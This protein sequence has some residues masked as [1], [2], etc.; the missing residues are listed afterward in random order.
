M[1]HASIVGPTDGTVP[2]VK[3][4]NFT[5]RPGSRW[6]S[7]GPKRGVA[8][9]ARTLVGVTLG[10]LAAYGALAGAS[11]TADAA[12]AVAT[13]AAT[14]SAAPSPKVEAAETYGALQRNFYV[15]SE[16][17]YKGTPANSC[18]TYSCLWPFTNATAGTA[19]LAGTP[20]ESLFVSGVNARVAGLA[21]YADDTEV[22]PGG[23]PQPPAYESAVAPPLGPGGATYYDDNAWVGLNLV[24]AYQETSRTKDLTLAQDEFDFAVAGWDASSTDGCPGGIFWEDVAGSQR[25]ATANGANAEL[26]AELALLT[27]DSSDLTWAERIY[28]WAVTCLGTSSGLYDDHVEPNGS[29]DSTVWS[30]NQGVMVG[31]GVLLDK[32]T[33]TGAYLT[34]AEQTASAAVAH[35]GTGSVLVNQGTAFNAIYFRDLYL[36]NQVA[37]DSAYAAEAQSFATTMWSQR[38]PTGLINPQYG[39]NG[40]APMIEIFGLLAGSPPTP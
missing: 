27:N 32:A 11:A 31:A 21:H 10:C 29:V 13:P 16:H 26:G 3:A 22:S 34:Q 4:Q 14:P 17:L 36:L 35:F 18:A 28:Q 37:P 33:G 24:H 38:Q 39:V 8:A 9:R 15:A 20:G 2:G 25:N 12:T 30:Y 5:V 40:T 19:F 23:A 7:P 1:S 6:R